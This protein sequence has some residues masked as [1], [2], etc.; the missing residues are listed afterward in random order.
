[1]SEKKNTPAVLLYQLPE[2]S[3]QG[4]A[5]RQYLSGRGIRAITVSPADGGKTLATLLGL[6]KE[7][8]TAALPL[9]QEPVV[10]LYGLMGPAFDDFLEFLGQTAP[11][12]LKAAA[13]PFNLRWSF[14][15]LANELARE[16]QQV[17]R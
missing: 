6:K 5:I 1:M 2:F 15:R 4:R 17:G 8:I 3:A 11:V 12:R 10:V 16:R 13:T 7:A 9:P 14:S